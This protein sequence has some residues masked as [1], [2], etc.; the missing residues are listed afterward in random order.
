[1]KLKG[2]YVIVNEGDYVRPGDPIMDGPTNPHEILRVMGEKAVAAYITDEI[3]EVYRLQGVKI[4][5]KHIEVIVTQ[6]LKKDSWEG[7]KDV[8]MNQH[9]KIYEKETENNIYNLKINKGKQDSLFSVSVEVN[10]ANTRQYNTELEDT[11]G[12]KI[13]SLGLSKKNELND[14]FYGKLGE[15]LKSTNQ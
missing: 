4:D 7:P 14:D 3:Q 11:L 8:S 2:R 9:T 6:M 15:F 10:D 12:D 13:N 1:M 5:D